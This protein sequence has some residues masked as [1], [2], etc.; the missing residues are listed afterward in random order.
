[1]GDARKVRAVEDCALQRAG[2]QQR[3]GFLGVHGCLVWERVFQFLHTSVSPA[4][5]R[6]S[7]TSLGGKS[8]WGWRAR[9]RRSERCRE[10]CTA[11]AKDWE[12]TAPRVGRRVRGRW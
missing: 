7:C 6:M 9:L 10:Q 12:N 2:R 1:G 4:T 11:R 3:L 8:P 5:S